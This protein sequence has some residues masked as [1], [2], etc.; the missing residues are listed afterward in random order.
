MTAMALAAPPLEG[1]RYSPSGRGAMA[2]PPRPAALHWRPARCPWPL[3]KSA[4]LL[5]A[6]ALTP[7][8]PCAS[9]A[10]RHRRLAGGDAPSAASLAA[11]PP[12]LVA[13]PATT[14]IA[15]IP[16]ASNSSMASEPARA[17]ANASAHHGLS[18]R[19]G[20][21]DASQQGGILGNA[22]GGHANDTTWI[23]GG[24]ESCRYIFGISKMSWAIVCDIL[25]LAV[26]LLC[27][28]MLLTCS[29]RRPPGTPLFDCSCGSNLEDPMLTG[30]RGGPAWR[31]R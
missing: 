26:V 13:S 5:F 22:A 19:Q 28:P 16:A 4:W 27:V 25:A 8:L 12:H 23:A 30:F 29:K 11:L 7:Q 10:V 14:A 18:A 24:L 17:G 6:A 2:A 31:S 3:A 1:R 21:A 20:L 9:G 15:H